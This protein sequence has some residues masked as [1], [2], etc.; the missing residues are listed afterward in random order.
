MNT[1]TAHDVRNRVGCALGAAFTRHD[2][3]PT[4]T[5]PDVAQPIGAYV[6]GAA[7]DGLLLRLAAQLEAAVPWAGRVPAV[8][9]GR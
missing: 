7:K 5:L 4:P 9:A 1:A 3:V 6:A 8:W 2:V